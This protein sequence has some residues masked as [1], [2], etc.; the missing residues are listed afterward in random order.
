V[1]AVVFGPQALNISEGHFPD[2]TGPV[3][4]M[5]VATPGAANV[6]PATNATP[7]LASIPAQTIH[8][9]ETI[10]FT[11]TATDLDAPPQTLAFSLDSA[12]AG[13]TIDP[14][15]GEFGWTPDAEG[16]EQV[17][18]AR[19]RVTDDGNPPASAAV[20]VTLI[21]LPI[22]EIVALP[23]TSLPPGT[24]VGFSFGTI[25]GR[26]YQVEFADR[27]VPPDWQPYGLP[28]T[29]EAAAYEILD[30]SGATQRF[31]RVRESD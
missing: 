5:P 4:A 28:F 8:R 17:E 31:F 12:P 19:V 9:G 6:G 30:D 11:A 21:V 26:N 14:V 22:P 29:A 7:Q 18:V 3:I 13:S 2:G 15:T 16:P 27:L 10:R 25:V 1:D 23:I 20:D 24:Q